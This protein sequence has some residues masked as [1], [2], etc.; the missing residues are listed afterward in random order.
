MG[1]TCSAGELGQRYCALHAL[2]ITRSTSI[3][4]LI[5]KPPL[6]SWLTD[7]VPST[8]EPETKPGLLEQSLDGK[9]PETTAKKKTAKSQAEDLRAQFARRLA[10]HPDV[11]DIK[12]LIQ[13]LGLDLRKYPDLSNLAFKSLLGSNTSHECLIQFL[14]DPM[15]NVTAARNFFHYIQHLEGRPLR[16]SELTD[17]R[18]Y[19]KQAVALGLV[20]EEEI[21]L[22]LKDD[23]KDYVPRELGG[24]LPRSY[25]VVFVRA[26]WDGLQQSSVF[27]AQDLG[28]RTLGLIMSLMNMIDDEHRSLAR[29]IVAAATPPQLAYMTK[30]VSYKLLAWCQYGTVPE[31]SILRT[32]EVSGQKLHPRRMTVPGLAD[33]IDS[34]PEAVVQSSL[35][36]TTMTLLSRQ[37]E[38]KVDDRHSRVVFKTWINLL[39]RSVQFRS[40]VLGSPEWETVERQL[41]RS[42]QT[43][44]I[45]YL[46]ALSEFDQCKFIVRNWVHDL[47]QPETGLEPAK[48]CLAVMRRFHELCD[49]RGLARC[50][51]N[52]I[53]A[54]YN[55]NQLNDSILHD[56]L[57]LLRK[58]FRSDI[59]IQIV[60]LLQSC[61][62]PAKA[63]I[64]GAEVQQYSRIDLG[65]A[66]RI[67]ELHQA[68]ALEG[69]PDLAIAL[70]N[71]PLSHVDI[72]F[73]L[74]KRH[75]PT[76]TK[77][78]KSTRPSSN[79]RSHL[80]HQM[81]AA[82]AH[83]SHLNPSI[84]FRKVRLC[85][86]LLNRDRSP[87]SPALVR[88]LTHAGI[89]RRLQAGESVGTE[90]IQWILS[91]VREVEGDEVEKVVDQAIY[92]WRGEVKAGRPRRPQW[93]ESMRHILEKEV[94]AAAG[95][96]S[97]AGSEV[98]Q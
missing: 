94:Y 87:L 53:L 77:T 35:V 18:R 68:L 30:R 66:L 4:L 43:N 76:T 22:I 13:E 10:S 41:A 44:I 20:S 23:K 65:V 82:F 64:L 34:L 1:G 12:N 7:F 51:N 73:R 19:I 33:Y 40:Q 60:E 86:T 63:A 46:E 2:S 72:T 11:R 95:N 97:Q 81:A 78:R 37:Q 85:Y 84:A 80:L 6:P 16:D 42:M 9:R 75:R 88:A 69:C 74:F 26:I 48:V 29:S 56:S 55:E 45:I 58:L 90:R 14:E 38:S 79:A 62:I 61:N 15:L 32:S 3:D 25:G 17:L 91:K 96:A 36:K 47:V 92:H 50:Y 54:L 70:I 5:V 28:G 21:M 24:E 57:R 39:S 93:N 98:T 27:T 8:E 71:D 67:F 59:I 31:F 52:L 49:T 83:A 89:V